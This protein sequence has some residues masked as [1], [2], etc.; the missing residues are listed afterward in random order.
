MSLYRACAILSLMSA[1]PAP[2]QTNPVRIYNTAKL[3]LM[4]G[5]PLV[6]GTVSSPDPNVYCAMANS[7]FDYTW[8]EMQHSPLT[9]QEVAR[10]IY[11]CRG[12]SAMP[13]IRVPDATESDIQKATDIGAMGIIVPTV[14]T[15]EK[16]QAAVKWAKYPP[17]GRRSMG[18]GQYREM[19]GE[20]YR[21]TANDNMVVVIMI[22]TPIGVENAAKI[23][24]VP[25]IDV[26]FAASTDLGNF[27]GYKIGDSKY[28]ALVTRIHDVTLKAGLRLGG[29]LMWKDRAGFTF[30]QGPGEPALIKSGAKISLEQKQ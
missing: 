15:V 7:G 22:E 21:Q 6:G 9:Y 29:P 13:F 17:V 30:F 28:E 26:I 2:G 24:D 25:G 10:M 4:Q 19:W 1:P 16:A 27:S 5:K 3:K 11:A 18:S 8:I 12:S 20:D 23:A 14:D